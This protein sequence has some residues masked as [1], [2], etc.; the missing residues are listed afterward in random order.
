MRYLYNITDNKVICVSH[1]A[2]KAVRGIAKCDP[3]CDAFN[4]ET[5]I[6]LAT[7][8][9]DEKVARKRA[10]RAEEKYIAAIKAYEAAKAE[11][12]AMQVY[13]NDAYSIH[14]EART[15][16]LEFENSLA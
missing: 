11:V 3:N 5:G 15:E 2:G 12:A 10:K 8:R 9:C 16:L 14:E 1:F 13:L 4:E 7:L 6:K